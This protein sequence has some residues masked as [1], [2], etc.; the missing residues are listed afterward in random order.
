MIFAKAIFGASHHRRDRQIDER[1]QSSALEIS[2][3]GETYQT[4]EWSLSGVLLADYFGPRGTGDEVEGSVQIT[5]DLTSHPFKAVVVR[6]DPAMG[7]LALNFTDLGASGFAALE[8]MTMS[9]YGL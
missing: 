7:Q 5:R 8:A 1:V 2:L 4:I 6:R 3:D 9:R